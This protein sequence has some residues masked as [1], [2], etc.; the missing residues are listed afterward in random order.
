MKKIFCFVV[1]LLTMFIGTSSIYAIGSISVEDNIIELNKGEEKTFN[2]V[3]R[4]VA[5]RIDITSS[6]NN[7][8]IVSENDKLWVDSDR[9]GE[10][11]Y[12][13]TIK[14]LKEGTAKIVIKPTDLAIYEDAP[15]LYSGDLNLTINVKNSMSDNGTNNNINNPKTGDNIYLY[16]GLG[17]LIVV[18]S[19]VIIYFIRQ[20]KENK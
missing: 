5:G 16:I 8:V 7:V 20:K 4:N 1:I 12:S 14:G 13:I 10:K 3:A 15:M 18:F 17:L 11:T 9:N 19:I 2:L 6:D